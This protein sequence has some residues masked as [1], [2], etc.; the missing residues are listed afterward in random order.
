MQIGTFVKAVEEEI[1]DAKST[2]FEVGL[3][4]PQGAM[5]YHDGDFLKSQRRICWAFDGAS[6]APVLLGRVGKGIQFVIPVGTNNNNTN[7]NNCD[8]DRV[9]F[10]LRRASK[11]RVTAASV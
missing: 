3:P 7:N 6:F 2:F 11:D 4:G 8:S 1:S 10:A 9:K 5:F